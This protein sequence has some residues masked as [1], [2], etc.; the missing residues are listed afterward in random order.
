MIYRLI[1]AKKQSRLLP[2]SKRWFH[3]VKIIISD[4]FS[5]ETSAEKSPFVSLMLLP[6]LADSSSAGT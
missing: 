4:Y 2:L 6:F 1:Y 3:N 5:D